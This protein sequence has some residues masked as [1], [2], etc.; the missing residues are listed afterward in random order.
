MF[1][2]TT[3]GLNL[4][5]D[6]FLRLPSRKTDLYSALTGTAKNLVMTSQQKH[7]VCASSTG[8]YVLGLHLLLSRA[9]DGCRGHVRSIVQVAMRIKS[10]VPDLLVTLLGAPAAAPRL[11]EELDRQ[12]HLS[13]ASRNNMQVITVEPLEALTDMPDDGNAKGLNKALKGLLECQ[14]GKWPV[15][16]SVV[17]F[18]VKIALPHRSIWLFS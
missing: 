13:E 16:P 15:V 17:I 10:L 1:T 12:K 8:W 9:A 6:L 2:I 14:L 18:D 3:D 5:C 7:L 4:S 11:V